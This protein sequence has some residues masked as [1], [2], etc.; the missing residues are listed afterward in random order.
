MA[1]QYD[2][3]IATKQMEV[4]HLQLSWLAR[5]EARDMEGATAAREKF[6]LENSALTDLTLKRDEAAK[7]EID[8]T[9]RV[10]TKV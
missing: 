8:E 3:E 10:Q 4:D 6:T 2:R 9:K 7:R 1:T 5:L